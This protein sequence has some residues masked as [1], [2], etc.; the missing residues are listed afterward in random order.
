MPNIRILGTK[1]DAFL[2]HRMKFLIKEEP[3]ML[4]RILGKQGPEVSVLGLG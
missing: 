3:M 4:K 2:L 1:I